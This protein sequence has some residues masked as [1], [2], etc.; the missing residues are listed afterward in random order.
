MTGAVL[1]HGHLASERRLASGS[2]PRRAAGW[3][4]LMADADPTALVGDRRAAEGHSQNSCT[5]PHRTFSRSAV[6]GAA[7]GVV[8]AT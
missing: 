8:T 4:V 6:G 5:P 2:Q 1:E 7:T 3:H